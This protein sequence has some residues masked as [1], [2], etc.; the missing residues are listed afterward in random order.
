MVRLRSLGVLSCAKIYGVV[1]MVI[2]LLFGL[3]FVL[4]GLVGLATAPGR[5]KLG[6]LGVLVVAAL[7]PFIYGAFGFV[8]GALAALF[9]NWVASAVGGIQMEL[10]A[11]PSPYVATPTQAAAP[12]V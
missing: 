2:G 6:M 4:I 1:N 11:V 5:G 12:L 10:E 9:Y 8:I 3:I 7:S